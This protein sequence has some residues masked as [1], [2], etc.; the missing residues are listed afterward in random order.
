MNDICTTDPK[1][2]MIEIQDTGRR[3][4]GKVAYRPT[5]ILVI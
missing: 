3:D 5:N 4:S 1:Q 2:M